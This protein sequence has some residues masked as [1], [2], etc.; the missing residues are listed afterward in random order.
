M[1]VRYDPEAD[2]L[3]IIFREEAAVESSDEARPGIIVD[4]D[5]T[6]EVVAIEVLDASR[7]IADPSLVEFQLAHSG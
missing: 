1:K 2:A 7:R 4:L 3:T 5:H 6:G